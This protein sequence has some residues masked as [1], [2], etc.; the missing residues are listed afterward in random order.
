MN[1]LYEYLKSSIGF[2]SKE[3]DS[4]FEKIDRA[5]F[6]LDEHKTLAYQD[7]PLPI[8]H[9]GT[10]SQPYTVAFMINK[11]DPRPGDKVLDVGAG[12]GWTTALL[13]HIVGDR[14]S[15]IGTEIIQELVEFG[16]FNLK[17]YHYENAKIVITGKELGFPKQA[18]YDKIL[19]SAAAQRM[20]QDLIKQM[21]I[22]GR[23]VVPV[24]NSVFVMDKIFKNKTRTEEYPGF[25]FV[26]LK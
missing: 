15:V 6:V 18:P 1:Q 19:V 22:G 7:F 3:I 25:A 5:D 2:G 8:G 26:P 14:G 9:S 13:A 20:P 24:Q 10:I 23:M 16:N 11:L 12:S 17:K 21:K 4:A